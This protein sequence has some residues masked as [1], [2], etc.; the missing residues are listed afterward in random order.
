MSIFKNFSGFRQKRRNYGGRNYG[1]RLYQVTQTPLKSRLFI[2]DSQPALYK[3][4]KE[5]FGVEFILG[6]SFHLS[7]GL[8]REFHARGLKKRLE[9]KEA[10]EIKSLFH[11]IKMYPYFPNDIFSQLVE[12]ARNWVKKTKFEE[13]ILK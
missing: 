9:S 7:Q 2:S 5:I 1:T 8:T 12:L 10:D 11:S 4:V 6:C 3:H 13:K